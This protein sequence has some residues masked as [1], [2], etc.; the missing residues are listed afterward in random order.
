MSTVE[1]PPTALLRF[2]GACG[3]RDFLAGTMTRLSPPDDPVIHFTRASFAYIRQG[4]GLFGCLLVFEPARFGLVATADP[5][6]L[7]G[8][9]APFEAARDLAWVPP[10]LVEQDAGW[11]R[12]R[13]QADLERLAGPTLVDEARVMRATLD[14]YFAEVDAVWES[15]LDR[16]ATPWFARPVESRRAVLGVIGHPGGWTGVP[17]PR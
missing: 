11:E 4:A 8:R 14:R 12:M 16:S 5:L 9:E 7:L 6:V 3:V 17:T 2:P 13:G 1:A 10:R 15:G